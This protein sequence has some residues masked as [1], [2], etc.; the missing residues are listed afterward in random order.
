[1]KSGYHFN[2]E[3]KDEFGQVVKLK[4]TSL[5]LTVHVGSVPLCRADLLSTVEREKHSITVNQRTSPLVLHMQPE[6][7]SYTLLDKLS[8]KNILMKMNND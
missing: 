4:I 7:Q 2:V 3:H 6:R 5:H 1:M 8:L